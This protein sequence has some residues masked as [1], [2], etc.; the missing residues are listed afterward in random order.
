MLTAL[1]SSMM[2]SGYVPTQIDLLLPKPLT[3]QQL[4]QALSLV[5]PKQ[6]A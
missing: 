4:K 6:E 3:M 2:E 1:G 5:D